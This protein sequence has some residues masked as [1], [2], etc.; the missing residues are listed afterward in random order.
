[1][2]RAHGVTLPVGPGDN[3]IQSQG[4]V[5]H[6]KSPHSILRPSLKPV[7]AIPESSAAL[8]AFARPAQIPFIA[9]PAWPNGGSGK[10]LILP[11]ANRVPRYRLAI[12]LHSSIHSSG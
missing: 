1:M 2:T 7:I 10:S 5:R 6:R 4:A 8:S 3:L 11:R 12:A 9:W